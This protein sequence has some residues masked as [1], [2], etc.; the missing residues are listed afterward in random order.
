MV[1]RKSQLVVRSV[2]LCWLLRSPLCALWL[3]GLCLGAMTIVVRAQESQWPIQKREGPFHFH[4]E[5]EP[6]EL[7][8]Y[9]QCICQLPSHLTNKLGLAV[10]PNRIHVVLMKDDREFS[11][12]MQHYFPQ[13]PS[14]RALFIQDRGPGIIF[15]YQHTELKTDLRH[16][17]T[18][19]LVQQAC[20]ALPIWL[21]EGLA[22]YFEI[23][24]GQEANHTTHLS[25]IQQEI[26][27]GNVPSLEELE[28]LEQSSQMDASRYSQAWGWVQFLLDG[29]PEAQQ[30]LRGFLSDHTHPKCAAGHLS[31]RLRHTIPDWR[32]RFIHHFQP[33]PINVATN[34]QLTR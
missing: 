14:R 7:D 24:P 12:Y 34:P 18:H 30:L 32:H 9:S 2:F 22:E 20:P 21:D 15:A 26:R 31:W 5:V 16:E 11:K 19:A 13:V 6:A 23:D 4:C 28:L 29:P 8:T 1:T 10:T 17:A 25:Y 3:T 27:V 33:P